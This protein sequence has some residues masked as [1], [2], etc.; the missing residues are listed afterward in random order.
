MSL[1]RDGPT[2]VIVYTTDNIQMNMYRQSKPSSHELTILLLYTHG[3]PYQ[4]LMLPG[5]ILPVLIPR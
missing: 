5:R 2:L 1:L 3:Y 4:Y